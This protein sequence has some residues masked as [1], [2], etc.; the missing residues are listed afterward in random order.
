MLELVKVDQYKRND[1]ERKGHAVVGSGR[2]KSQKA[3]Y[4][5]DQ[6]KDK[7][8]ADI[9]TEVDGISAHNASDHVIEHLHH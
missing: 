2:P 9:I 8:R 1:T 6:N 4:V 7:D 3:G 5:A